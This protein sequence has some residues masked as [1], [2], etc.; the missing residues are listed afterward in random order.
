[1]RVAR[2]DKSF[3]N[4]QGHHPIVN[5]E[6]WDAVPSDSGNFTFRQVD[7]LDA[8]GAPNSQNLY[9]YPVGPSCSVDLG[10]PDQYFDMTGNLIALLPVGA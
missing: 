3:A 5:V 9:Q 1:M 6:E 4:G 10:A 7:H 2:I 8:T